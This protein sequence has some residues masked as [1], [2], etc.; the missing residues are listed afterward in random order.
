M[1]DSE[2]RE[3]FEKA[4]KAKVPVYNKPIIDCYNCSGVG[5]VIDLR[6][7]RVRNCVCCL[8]TGQIKNTNRRYKRA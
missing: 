5:S 1:T 2:T 4:K 6:S 7:G 3:V 8:G